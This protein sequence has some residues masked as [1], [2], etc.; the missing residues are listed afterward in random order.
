MS[1]RSHEPEWA[2]IWCGRP[3]VTVEWLELAILSLPFSKVSWLAH[4]FLFKQILFHLATLNE[5]TASWNIIEIIFVVWSVFHLS[6]ITHS[7]F[8][9]TLQ[10]WSEWSDLFFCSWLKINLFK[11][12]RSREQMRCRTIVHVNCGTKNGIQ[13]RVKTFWWRR[14]CNMNIN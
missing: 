11:K 13:H 2:C 3:T 9:L 14:R 10:V 6:F 12:Q 5:T 8:I 7:M 1:S 4:F